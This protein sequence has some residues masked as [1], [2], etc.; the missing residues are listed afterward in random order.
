MADKPR[1]DWSDPLDLDEQ[2]TRD[3][4]LIRDS[5]REYAQARLMTR[6]LMANREERF[7]REIMN[8]M[9]ELG[10]LGA[11]LP[12]K[13]GCAEVSHVAYGL[14]AREIERVDSGYR[15]AMSVQL[16]LIHI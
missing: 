14:I 6:V 13:Y 1:F 10:L 8:E 4:R 2:L 16:S 11:T 12:Q 15:S 7:H 5:T 3:E 9:G